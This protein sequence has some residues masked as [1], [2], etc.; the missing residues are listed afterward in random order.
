VK[1]GLLDCNPCQTPMRANLKLGKESSSAEVDATEYRSL[2][3]S[4]RYLV[5][6]GPDLAFSIGY[7]SRF[8]EDPHEVHL[9]AVKHILRFIA[10]TCD[11]LVTDW[12]K[13]SRRGKQERRYYR[14]RKQAR[15]GNGDTV[16]GFPFYTPTQ[17]NGHPNRIR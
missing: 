3:G 5:H 11:G 13:S 17:R 8:L 12:P 1:G 4:L 2:V 15:L 9:A 16:G 10:G 14:A 7:V 6:T